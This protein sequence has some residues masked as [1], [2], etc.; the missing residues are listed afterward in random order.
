MKLKSK[1]YLALAIVMTVLALVFAWTIAAFSDNRGSIRDLSMRSAII[2]VI[3][4]SEIEHLKLV[5][6]AQE[7]IQEGPP[8]STGASPDPGK[9]GFGL[10][11]SS[12]ERRKAEKELPGI[13]SALKEVEEAH[14]GLHKSFAGISEALA[15][16]NREAAQ[17]ILDKETRPR[18]AEVLEHLGA[19][20]DTVRRGYESIQKKALGDASLTITVLT[21]LFIAAMIIVPLVFFYLGTRFMS[22]L[23]GDASEL[24]RTARSIAGGDLTVRIDYDRK[25]S[26]SALAAMSGMRDALESVLREIRDTSQNLVE[27]IT[28]ICSGNQS[29]SQRSSEQAAAIEEIA[30]T[31]EQTISIIRRNAEDAARAEEMYAGMTRMAQSGGEV[32]MEAVEF[33]SALDQPGGKLSE[34]H[35]SVREIAFQANLLALSAAVEADRTGERVEGFAVVAEEVQSLARRTEEA[36]REIGVLIDDSAAGAEEAKCLAR[37]GRDAMS[38]IIA[39]V[40]DT[41]SLISGVALASGEQLKGIGQISSAITEIESLAQQ[42]ASLVVE[43]AAAS[44]EVASRARGMLLR[45]QG[46]RLRK[47][48]FQP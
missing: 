23:G 40:R 20:D 32:V 16:G 29:I 37:R 44:E 3:K 24:M 38:G 41:G 39:S 19:M 27:S 46:F 1:M 22:R 42:D 17:L 25:A 35:S 15:Q 31:L 28:R 2:A 45:I 47:G 36:A 30:A 34:I 4:D 14:A 26:N 8:G 10:W 5:L 6:E 18:L 33:I 12:E 43:T 13:G 7:A 21:G 48:V 9:C 11:Y